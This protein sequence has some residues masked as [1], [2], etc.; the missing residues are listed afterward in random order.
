MNHTLNLKV[1]VLIAETIT[2]AVKLKMFLWQMTSFK[3]WIRSLWN[4][5]GSIKSTTLLS[6]DDVKV[7]LKSSIT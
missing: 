1:Q 6:K 4:S 5:P 7:L 3:D 2:Y